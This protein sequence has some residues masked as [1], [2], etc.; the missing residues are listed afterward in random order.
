MA[1]ALLGEPADVSRV[2]FP[3]DYNSAALVMREVYQTRGEIWTLVAPK[4]ESIP[5]LFTP[6]EAAQLFHDGA[7]GLD[8]AGHQADQPRVILAAVGASFAS[9]ETKSALSEEIS[10]YAVTPAP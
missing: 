4:A 6:E 5:D 2:L 9:R 1:E 8:W 10:S 3:A 7:L